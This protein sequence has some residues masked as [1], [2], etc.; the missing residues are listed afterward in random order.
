M[1]I[2]FEGRP[3]PINPAPSVTWNTRSCGRTA[4]DRDV[5]RHVERVSLRTVAQ[6]CC[7][8]IRCLADARTHDFCPGNDAGLDTLQKR[9]LVRPA[10]AV[11]AM[12]AA[13]T[14]QVTACGQW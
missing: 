4:A 5:R 3:P 6:S 8:R 14:P 12:N 7:N 10:T 2:R 9:P 1:S 11:L 13:A